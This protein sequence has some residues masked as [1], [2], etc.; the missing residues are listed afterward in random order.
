MN[1]FNKIKRLF[2]VLKAKYEVRKYSNFTIAEYFRKQGAQVGE[3]CHIGIRSLASEPYLIKIGNHVGIAKGTTLITHTSGWNFRDKH[4][5][6]H[7]FG[8]IEIQDN[9]YIGANVTV[10]PNV[11]IGKNCLVSAGAVVTKD[12]PNN[13]IIGGVPAKVIGRMEDF[14][15]KILNI[16][17][18]QKPNDYLK[19]LQQGKFYST[20]E[21]DRIKNSRKNKIILREHLMKY[22]WDK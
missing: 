13:S 19:E 22:F 3:D 15:P 1:Y 6:L 2:I 17:E 21:I 12:M 8:K 20:I 18:K 4:P 9:T 16:W 7:I 14:Y 10:L 5:D 11:T